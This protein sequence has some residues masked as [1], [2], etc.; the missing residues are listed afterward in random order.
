MDK[1]PEKP[2]NISNIS[3]NSLNKSSHSFAKEAS[4]T[5]E[6]RYL[7]ATEYA[8]FYMEIRD[9]F[10]ILKKELISINMIRRNV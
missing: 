3:N 1:T 7:D 9:F 4:L 2:I 5:Q 6:K 10:I 8:F